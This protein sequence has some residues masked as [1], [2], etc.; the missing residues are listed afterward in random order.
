MVDAG[1]RRQ[2]KS[3]DFW[4][5]CSLQSW[6]FEGQTSQSPGLGRPFPTPTA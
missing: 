4:N 1:V 5:F 6:Q 2:E 3:E